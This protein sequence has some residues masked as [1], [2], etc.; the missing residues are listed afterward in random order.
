MTQHHKT[1]IKVGQVVRPDPS[2]VGVEG[3]NPNTY[4][5]RVEWVGQDGE[6]NHVKVAG[7]YLHGGAPGIQHRPSAGDA[8]VHSDFGWCDGW[9]ILEDPTVAQEEFDGLLDVWYNV[10]ICCRVNVKDRTVER[11]VIIME[12]MTMDKTNT[13]MLPGYTSLPPELKHWR[14][15]A[16]HTA[17]HADWP[18]TMEWGF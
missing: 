4:D 2:W 9:E 3:D 1:K 14:A 16:K 5:F 7:R 10:P 8:A 12:D 15:T 13:V 11:T 18:G 6:S 17:D